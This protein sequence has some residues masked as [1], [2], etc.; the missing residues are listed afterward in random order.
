MLE[1][2]TVKKCIFKLSFVSKY[3]RYFPWIENI[4][5][6]CAS[7]NKQAPNTKEFRY[8]FKVNFQESCA[9]TKQSYVGLLW[10][11]VGNYGHVY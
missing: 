2:S 11:V 4:V 7:L 9:I 10:S 8:D 5:I 1:K 3:N 6:L